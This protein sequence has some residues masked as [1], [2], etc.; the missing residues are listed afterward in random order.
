MKLARKHALSCSMTPSEDQPPPAKKTRR[1]S[2]LSCTHCHIVKLKCDRQRP[3]GSCKSRGNASNCVYNPDPKKDQSEVV[4]LN[5]TPDYGA[6]FVHHVAPWSYQRAPVPQM[7]VQRSRS[8]ENELQQRLDKL[9]LMIVNAATTQKSLDVQQS[10]PTPE[11]CRDSSPSLNSNKGA[12]YH[13][14]ALRL[15]GSDS[16]YV[17]ETAYA[18]ILAEVR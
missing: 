7:V 2:I 16:N 12:A 8:K 17:G 15:T 10:Y 11:E 9:E 18:S 5:D 14:G 13:G 1:R 4:P 3:C 6:E